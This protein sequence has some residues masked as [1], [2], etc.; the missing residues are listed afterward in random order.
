M[1][2]AFVKP[3]YIDAENA[4]NIHIFNASSKADGIYAVKSS[5]C[6]NVT[7]KSEWTPLRYEE[8][9]DGGRSYAAK[10]ENNENE[11]CG[12]C[13]ATLYSDGK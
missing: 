8:G 9:K 4:R 6:G 3:E 1:G 12:K 5:C 10:L 11:T 7:R 2:Y 13:V